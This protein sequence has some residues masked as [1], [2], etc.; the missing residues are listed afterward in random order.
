MPPKLE[1]CVQS[2]M[3]SSRMMQKYPDEKERKSH[4]FAICTAALQKGGA[5]EGHFGYISLAKDIQFEADNAVSSWIQAFPL[6]KWEHPVFGTLEFTK[7][8]VARFVENLKNKVTGTDVSIDFRHRQDPAK[9]GQAAGWVKEAEDRGD[10]GL[11]LNVEWTNDAA[12][13][14]KE[15]KWRYFSPEYADEWDNKKGQTFTDVLFGG[16]LTNHP[17]LRDIAA[18][19]LED[20]MK[21]TD[22]LNDYLH[23]LEGDGIKIEDVLDEEARTYLGIKPEPTDPK[24]Y[25]EEMIEAEYYLEG[26]QLRDIPQSERERHP[27][28]DF[29][30]KGM[31]FPIFTCEDANAAARSLG[32][33]GGANY[34]SDQLKANIIRI[35]NRKGFQRCLPEAWK[36]KRAEEEVNMEFLKQLQERMGLA[37]TADEDTISVRVG[38]LQD[39]FD[40]KSNEEEKNKQFEDQFPDEYKRLTQLETS[41]RDTETKF[42]LSQWSDKG[43]PAVVHDRIKALR[44]SLSDDNAVKFDEIITTICK[45]GLVKLSENGA[46]HG[47]DTELE[48]SVDS[49]IKRLMDEDD[50][51]SRR[52][53]MKRVFSEHKDWA[54]EYALKGGE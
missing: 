32:R 15:K 1:R 31:S 3:Q 20:F 22:Y 13:E 50:S 39:F 54:T 27:A 29:A 25:L 5:M 52:D 53:A 51:L 43:L 7:D 35:A 4:A 2:I 40:A 38:E 6:G 49:E 12:K 10:E 42:R 19:N 33:A 48:A 11:W 16:A 44:K 8:R 36:T 18:V 14:I 23:A 24:T 26:I 21:D 17:F 28:S 34:G 37:T 46:S 9:G 41:R 47:L 45:L 30:G